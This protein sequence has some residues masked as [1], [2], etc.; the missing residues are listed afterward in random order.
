MA[1]M[2][3]KAGFANRAAKRGRHSKLVPTVVDALADAD[4]LPAGFRSLLKNSLP[5]VLSANKA[6]RHAYETEVVGQAENALK[7]V[8]AALEKKHAAAV[9]AQNEIITPNENNRRIKAKQAA[10]AHLEAT[11]QKLEGNKASVKASNKA[12]EDA[13]SAVKEAQKEEK[14]AE[15]ELQR[16]VGKKA[17]LVDSLANEFEGLK[18]GTLV[19]AAGQ[20]AVSK[21]LSLGKEYRLGSDTLWASLPITCKKAPEVRTEFENSVFERVKFL[22]DGQI[23][24][25]TK[26][27]AELEPVK[28]GKVNATAG[29]K[30]ALEAAQA[31]L[32]AAE[33]ELAATQE[34][35][36]NA[37]KEVGKADHV[38]RQI[39]HDMQKVC[40]AQ[41]SLAKEVANF[42]ENVWS[43]FNQLK[44]KEPEP[45]PVAEP[46]AVEAAPAE[47]APADAAPTEG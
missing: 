47:A 21:L 4:V 30:G 23:A 10:E 24:E 11:K 44:N 26:K 39:W 34:A 28:A 31:A 18:G 13:E 37:H 1:P 22:I 41:D 3:R 38:L 16:F 15:K 7:T 12:V 19:K 2:K 20:K 43:A 36:K 40:D 32:T 27:V 33:N 6:D 9:A 5:I 45:E 46:A 8:Q 35:N 29:A 17:A 42:K 25:L 14:A